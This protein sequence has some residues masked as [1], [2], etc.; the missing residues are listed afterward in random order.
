MSFNI[1]K[2]YIV[3]MAC[4]YVLCVYLREK[5]Q[6]LFAYSVIDFHE[7]VSVHCTVRI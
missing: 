6:R 7:G 5:E 3:H 4:I 2:F 1:Q